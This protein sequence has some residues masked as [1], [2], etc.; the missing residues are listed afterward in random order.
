MSHLCDHNYSRTEPSSSQSTTTCQEADP[1][2]FLLLQVFFMR[3]LDEDVVFCRRCVLV[4]PRLAGGGRGRGGEAETLR[5]PRRDDS[6]RE[7][8]AHC[9]PPPPP[10][11]AMLEDVRLKVQ[12]TQPGPL[13]EPDGATTLALLSEPSGLSPTDFE[14]VSERIMAWM[15]HTIY[16]REL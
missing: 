11:Q 2:M 14:A 4:P 3:R 7:A 1:L 15:S 9:P 12:E 10:P 8:P 16:S 6:V 5:S 13:P